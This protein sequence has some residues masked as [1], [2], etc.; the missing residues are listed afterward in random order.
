MLFRS[1][2]KARAA[3]AQR[4]QLWDE[5]GTRSF[6]GLPLLPWSRERHTLAARL[7]ALDLPAPALAELVRI[8]EMLDAR[9][10]APFVPLSFAVDLAAYLPTAEKILWLATHEADEINAL[11]T[12]P[13]LLLQTVSEWSV[14][15]ISPELFEPACLLA[16]RLTSEHLR[17]QPMPMPNK[18]GK[19]R[20]SGN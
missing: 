5:E 6:A 17:V 15:V 18:K 13:T 12:R 11:R 19:G 3:A 16:H 9:K 7:V 2:S 20:D 10:D 14:S 1:D 8:R 4:E